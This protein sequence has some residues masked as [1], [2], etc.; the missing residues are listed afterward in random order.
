MKSSH[1]QSILTERWPC[2]TCGLEN[3]WPVAECRSIERAFFLCS[4][5]HTSIIRPTVDRGVEAPDEPTSRGPSISM[6]HSRS[7]LICDAGSP[8]NWKDEGSGMKGH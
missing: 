4:A 5:R 6:S 1:I 8:P 7:H 2:G 3:L